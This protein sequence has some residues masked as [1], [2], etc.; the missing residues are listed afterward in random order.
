MPGFREFL[1]RFRPAGSPGPAVGG[2]VP[3]DR[4][5]ELAAELSPPLALLDEATAEAAALVEAAEREAAE[6]RRHAAERAERTVS[7]ARAR[8]P[9]VRKETA[10]RL[11]AEAEAEAARA[12]AASRAYV[13][14]LRRRAAERTPALADRLVA[15]VA[16]ELAG[17][18]PGARRTGPAG[19]SQEASWARDGQRE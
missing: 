14:E 8:A 9:E 15:R 19:P 10:A 12:E 4:S 13:R 17:E 5:A 2:N 16:G 7:G 1:A 6:R 11:V 3:A 18:P